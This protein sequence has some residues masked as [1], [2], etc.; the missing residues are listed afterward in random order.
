MFACAAATSHRA[1]WPKAH[2]TGSLARMMAREWAWP[3][4]WVALVCVFPSSCAQTKASQID[5]PA[6]K[7]N[8]RVVK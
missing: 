5:G 4:V 3:V 7:N 6:C 1:I 8:E 2:S